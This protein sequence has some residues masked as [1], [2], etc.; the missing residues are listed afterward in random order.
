[1]ALGTPTARAFR[2]VLD[3][4]NQRYDGYIDLHEHDGSLFVLDLRYRPQNA[5]GDKWTFLHAEPFNENEITNSVKVL[6][7]TQRILDQ[8]IN[9]KIKEVFGAKTEK[10][11]SGW[12]LVQWIVSYQLKEQDNVISINR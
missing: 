12:E 1:M 10:P 2:F 8:V 6:A 5:T 4:E 3:G 9:P 11:I 7:E